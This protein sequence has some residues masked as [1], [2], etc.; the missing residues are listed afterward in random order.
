MVVPAPMGQSFTREQLVEVLDRL[1]TAGSWSTEHSA[2]LLAELDRAPAPAGQAP[3]PSAVPLGSRLAEAAAYAGAALVGAAGILLVGQRWE[4][5]GRPGR[6]AILAGVTV[7]LAVVGASVAAVRPRGRRVLLAPAHAV[8]RRLSSTALTIA[9]AT[10]AGTAGVI[11][12][13]HELL[14]VAVT[15]VLAVAVAEWVAPSAVSET[16][17]LGAACLLAGSIV[18]EAG[19]STTWLTLA[20]AA[21]GLGWA[22]LSSRSVLVVPALGLAL[23]LVLV[24]YSGAIAAFENTQPTTAIGIAVL[25]LLAVGGLAHFVR[26]SAWASAIVG[27]L[28]L[29]VLVLRI[30]TDSLGPVVAV[31]LTGLVLLGVGAVLLVRRRASGPR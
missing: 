24:L 13:S 26:H 6:V 8:R 23:G 31:L 20:L 22:A 25:A 29:A 5:L 27:V 16:A 10:A 1:E 19:V 12:T 11:A 2:A 17:A 18:E 4:D 14:A 3:L 9:A 7:V 21:V 15:A 28:A 30:S